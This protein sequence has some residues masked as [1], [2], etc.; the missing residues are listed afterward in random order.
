MANKKAVYS[1][2]VACLGFVC[3]AVG[4]TAVGL[5]MWGE[6]YNRQFH[7]YSIPTSNYLTTLFIIHVFMFQLTMSDMTTDIS[8]LGECVKNY[9]IT[10]KN[11]ELKWQ[12]SG[13]LVTHIVK[14][15]KRTEVV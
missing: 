8:D 10:E 6:F 13:L 1:A 5:P 2:S 11:V 15:F 7:F 3:L 9:C 12:G 14:I 4:A